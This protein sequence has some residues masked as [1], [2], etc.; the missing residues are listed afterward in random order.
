MRARTDP[1]RR[2]H[3]PQVDVVERKIFEGGAFR[4]RLVASRC[5]PRRGRAVVSEREGGKGTQRVRS[6]RLR[7]LQLL[8]FGPSY[9]ACCSHVG[10]CLLLSRHNSL[11]SI[12]AIWKPRGLSIVA[13]TVALV[14]WYC[15]VCTPNREWRVRRLRQG[16]L[17]PLVGH[18]VVYD[19]IMA[20]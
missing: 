18:P 12:P 19:K 10:L 17:F 20:R 7:C 3:P 5:V 16:P 2:G 8:V 14:R 9:W 1:V 4:R 6:F 13:V 11:G 15:F